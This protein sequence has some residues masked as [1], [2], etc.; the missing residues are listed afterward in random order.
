MLQRVVS[1]EMKLVIGL[2]NAEVIGDLDREH[3]WWRR[4][5]K[6]LDSKENFRGGIHGKLYRQLSSRTCCAA[7]QRKVV[8][9]G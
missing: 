5:S 7:G 2:S 3:F 4:R 9:D 8:T 1:G 6:S